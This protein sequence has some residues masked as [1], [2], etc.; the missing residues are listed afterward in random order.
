MAMHNYDTQTQEISMAARRTLL[1][2]LLATPVAA[3]AEE[4]LGNALVDALE[5]AF[6]IHPGMRRVHAKGR[7]DHGRFPPLLAAAQ[8]STAP[9]FAAPASVLLHFSDGP[10][11]PNIP[12]GD[13]NALSLGIG[14][15]FLTPGAGANDIVAS[16][17][18]GFPVRTGEDF[19]T[20]LRAIAASG[21]D[22]AQL[23]Y[24]ALF[25]QQCTR[26]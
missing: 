25:R 19:A 9:H 15:R 12:D 5:G 11:I 7:L 4:N 2:C 26:L 18:E 22:V 14:L 13:P 23:R 1:A 16:A 3:H 10:G 17:D 24:H 20:F 6:G 8:V 21:A